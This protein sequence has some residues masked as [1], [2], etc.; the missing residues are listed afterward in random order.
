MLYYYGNDWKEA[1][2]NPP[3]DIKSAKQLA[4]YEDNYNV[5]VPAN[6]VEEDKE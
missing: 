5:V 2:S 1:V 3:V 6:E 4:Q